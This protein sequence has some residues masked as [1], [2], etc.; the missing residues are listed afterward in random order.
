MCLCLQDVAKGTPE[1]SHTCLACSQTVSS[2]ENSSKRRLSA[3][4]GQG[5]FRLV[6]GSCPRHIT[7]Q[8]VDGA[9]RECP[10]R[11]STGDRLRHIANSCSNR[12]NTDARCHEEVRNVHENMCAL[13]AATMIQVRM[14]MYTYLHTGRLFSMLRVFRSISSQGREAA[15]FP[16]RQT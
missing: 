9:I 8:Q 13:S 6:L 16:L 15:T 5:H 1:P 7:A 10:R 14:F 2:S 12:G 3:E 4:S 11:V